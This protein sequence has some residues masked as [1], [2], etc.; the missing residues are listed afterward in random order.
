MD[1]SSSISSGIGSV[2]NSLIEEDG[3]E[4]EL[5]SNDHFK[6]LGGFIKLLQIVPTGRDLSVYFPVILEVR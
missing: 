2:A 4:N 3:I 6:Q 5:I 1:S